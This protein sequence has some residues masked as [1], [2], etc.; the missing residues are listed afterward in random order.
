MNALGAAR[1][2]VFDERFRFD[3][4]VAGDATREAAEAA[5]LVADSPGT[6][7]NPLI[8]RG[9]AG[10]GKSHLLGAVASRVR[11]LRPGCRVVTLSAAAQPM[12]PVAGAALVVVDDVRAG[13]EAPRAAE[14]RALIDAALAAGAQVVVA[15]EGSAVSREE[16]TAWVAAFPRARLVR[17]GPPDADVRHRIVHQAAASRSLALAADVIAGVAREPVDSVRELLN[18]LSRA[19]AAPAAPATGAFSLGDD[20][21]FASFLDEVAREVAVVAEPW[22][23]RLG[24]AASRWRAEGYDVDALERALR[25]TAAPDVGALL[26]TFEQAV[27]RL[28]EL[29]RRA[30]A[31]GHACADDPLF[32]DP[33][34][35]AEAEQLVTQLE[36]AAA[37]RAAA[38]RAERVVRHATPAP[39]SRPVVTAEGW[40][41]EWPDVRDLLV[42]AWR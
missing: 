15:E 28:R 21:D 5:R 13:L 30:A 35:V 22:R 38:E 6:R 32:G 40:V 33:S 9:G 7:W 34:R 2:L 24:E 17:L 16:A 4:F 42:E 18:R 37:E 27:A 1:T 29:A 36:R 10:L 14:L 3:T 11:E 39:T 20:G 31:H 23:V 26:A 25:L 19:G 41:L 8:V 12:P